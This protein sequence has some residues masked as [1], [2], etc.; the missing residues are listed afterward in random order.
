MPV[1]PF[2]LY[3]AVLSAIAAIVT[4]ADK[5]AAKCRTRR[6]PEAVLFTLAVLGGCGAMYLTMLLIRH[7]TLHKRFMLGLPT[8][9]LIQCAAYFVITKAPDLF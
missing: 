1:Q 5:C 6:V 8:I 7:K 3:L 9:L 2:F 4:I